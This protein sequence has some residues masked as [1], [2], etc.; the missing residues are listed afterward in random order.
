[1]TPPSER[2]SLSTGLPDLVAGLSVAGLL[3]PEAIAYASIAALP[4]QHGVIALLAG[5]ICYGLVGRSRFAIVS[6]TS[7]S[8]AVLAATTASLAGGDATHR[9]ALAIGLVLL[10]GAFFLIAGVA[11]MGGLS[12]FIAKPVLRGFTFGL[13]LVIIIR[14]LPAIVGVGASHEDFST[15][16]ST[17]WRNSIDGI[18]Q[19]WRWGFA[20]WLC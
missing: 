3:V 5:L 6:A 4:P 12:A 17:C 14:Q 7:S 8:A 15:T 13:A 19:A 18:R 2:P 1:M 9:L 16:R 10:T 11:R 20:R